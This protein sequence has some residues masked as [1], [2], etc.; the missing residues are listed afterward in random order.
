MDPV[1]KTEEKSKSLYKSGMRATVKTAQH[2]AL[3]ATI[4]FYGPISGSTGNWVGVELDAPLGKGTGTQNG[5]KYFECRNNYAMF[6]RTTQVKVTEED[7]GLSKPE[8]KAPAP[9]SKIKRLD[10]SRTDESKTDSSIEEK[11]LDR[12]TIEEV[13]LAIA[14]TKKNAVDKAKMFYKDEVSKEEESS[15][16]L[17]LIQKDDTIKFLKQELQKITQE[18]DQSKKKISADGVAILEMKAKTQLLEQQV[19]SKGGGGSDLQDIIETLTLEKEIAEGNVEGLQKELDDTKQELQDLKEEIELRNLE[20]EE[21]QAEAAEAT[22]S[23]DYDSTDYKL[24]LKRLYSE[25]QN[26]KVT[27]ENR[28]QQLENQLADVPSVEAK[29]KQ[30]TELKQ[31]LVNKHKEIAALKEQLEESSQ[32][33]E[34]IEKITEDN[35]NKTEKIQELTDRLKELQE[36]HELEEQIA[37]GQ[38]ELEKSL[39]AEIHDREVVIQNLKNELSKMEMQK[40]DYE[41]TINQFRVR[42]CEL[43]NDVESLKDQLADTGEEEKM[44]KMQTLMEKNV[45]INNKMR[46]MMT[47]H[48][49]GKLNEVQYISLQSKFSYMEF[50]IPDNVLEQMDM[51]T[52]TNY[53]LLSSLRGRTYILVSEVVRITIDTHHDKYLVRW[54]ANLATLCINLIYDLIGIEDFLRTLQAKDYSDFMNQIDWGQVLAISSGVDTFLRLLKEGGISSTISLDNFNYSVGVVHHFTLQNI[55]FFSG[56]SVLS[57]G[58]LQLSIGIYCL[59]QMYALNDAIAGAIDYKDLLSKSLS[60]GK[61]LLEIGGDEDSQ[62]LRSIAEVLSARFG[63]VTKIL[64]DNEIVDYSSYHWVDWFVAS[65]KDVKSILGLSAVKKA[66]EKKNSGAWNAQ[67]KLVKEKLSK[68][69]ETSRELEE[70][71][72]SIKANSIKMA[73]VEKDLNE[74]KIAKASLESRLADAHAKSQRLAQLEIEKKRLQDREKYFEESLDAVNSEIEKLQEIN[75]AL[76]DE[77]AQFKEKEEDSKVLASSNIVSTEQGGLL[78]L[79]R[80]SSITRHGAG[81]I[82]QDE[83]ETF[84]AI[85][86]HYK[87]QKQQLNS[88]IIKSQIREIPK[89]SNIETNPAKD[90]LD[91]MYATQAKL[92]KDISRLRVVDLSDKTSKERV[93]KEKENLR[94]CTIDAKQTLEGIQNIVSSD[95]GFG[96][97]IHTGPTGTLGKIV[98]GKGSNIIPVSISLEEF[99][100]FR[101]ILNLN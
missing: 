47:M 19:K 31:E 11:S 80:G 41:K 38:A 95:G 72:N 83:L 93:Q 97:F 36:L 55:Q 48:I 15:N 86:D 79:L 85:I 46:E 57:R 100:G 60:L 92:K 51:G 70:A 21:L 90:K 37:E 24:A 9:T 98:C 53:L 54:V 101:K 25:S 75:K 3:L 67:A 59:L 64:F 43:Q 81:P 40:V 76:E 14:N 88:K 69:E 44:K 45:I 78:N 61:S 26:A 5:V 66:E 87:I 10:E 91:S 63:A 30:I 8:P 17:A 84:S 35:Y 29:I 94:A 4:R 2:N 50:S 18:L 52:L 73:R 13:K 6:V 1:K 65:D 56:A 74:S 58:C 12:Q 68:A 71:R 16:E 89:F 32:Y 77:L 34:M 22:V 82:G 39:N 27:Y 62:P 28:I 96:S 49:N 23:Q 99:R 42:V 33:S 20:L 7:P